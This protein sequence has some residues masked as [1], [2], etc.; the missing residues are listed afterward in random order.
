[1]SKRKSGKQA[2][3]GTQPVSSVPE[4][5]PDEEL[6]PALR[7][8]RREAADERKRLRKIADVIRY[9]SPRY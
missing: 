1:M 4:A 2:D 6:P 9:T 8:D 3:K 5:L 7:K